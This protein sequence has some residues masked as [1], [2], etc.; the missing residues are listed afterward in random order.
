MMYVI[1]GHVFAC[2]DVRHSHIPALPWLTP[3]SR[4]PTAPRSAPRGTAPPVREQA[5]LSSLPRRL[6]E[7]SQALIGGGLN[8]LSNFRLCIIKGWLL[9]NAAI[10]RVSI[11]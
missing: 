4:P 3:S 1:S 7:L 8:A 10:A 5:R 11:G 2:R 6:W 9:Y